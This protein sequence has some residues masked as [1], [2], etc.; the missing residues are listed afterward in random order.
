MRLF[1]AAGLFFP[2]TLGGPSKSLYWLAKELVKSDVEVSVVTTNVCVDDS[3]IIA[4]K[5]MIYDGIRVRYCNT[6]LK[7]SLAVLFHGL[8]EI[9][10]CDI[11]LLSSISYFPLFF[12][13]L[14][15]TILGK[16]VIWSPRGEMLDN[17]LNNNKIKPIYFRI[18]RFLMASKVNFHA[19][20]IEEKESIIKFMGVN[21]KIYLIPNYIELPKTQIRNVTENYFLYV[22]RIAPIKAIDRLFNGLLLSESFLNSDYKLYIV[23]ENEKQFND[24]DDYLNKILDSNPILKKRVVFCGH[25]DGEEKF[26]IYSNAYFTFLI[27]HSENFGNVVVESLS[28]GTPVIA[29]KGTP[30]EILEKKKCGL[31]IDNSI[32]SI[33][34]TIDDILMIK[35]KEY[36]VMRNCAINLSKEF[37]V[38]QNI[39]KWLAVMN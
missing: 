39:D 13:S 24:Y 1:I 37:D 25:I 11:V 2:T 9:H 35:Q 32:E 28:Q 18:I 4:D 23:G 26:K 5:W 29:S 27:S 36:E 21:S 8:K 19:T 20:S 10:G 15:A 38:K 16:K 7:I 14:Y 17:A 12:L 3:E 31:Y 30:W 33:K 6:S 34:I 22:G